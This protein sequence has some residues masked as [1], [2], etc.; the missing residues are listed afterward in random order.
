ME[1]GY[2]KLQIGEIIREG[3]EMARKFHNRIGYH[4]VDFKYIGKP[5]TKDISIRRKKHSS[6]AD[7]NYC[8]KILKK[9]GLDEPPLNIQQKPLDEP[10][11][12]V[13]SQHALDILE[14]KDR[15]IRAGQAI[16]E[17]P[18]IQALGVMPHAFPPREV[19]GISDDFCTA[20]FDRIETDYHGHEKPLE[21]IT[22]GFLT[23]SLDSLIKSRS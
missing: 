4:L 9:I 23:R 18:A 10:R 13:L 14:R 6:K 8:D 15:E 21:L 17:M 2:K 11:K 20:D 3:D 12:V 16:R 22:G 1:K 5:R 7:E 19:N